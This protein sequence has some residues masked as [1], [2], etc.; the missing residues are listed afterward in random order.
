MKDIKS[1][2]I[3][4]L[5][6]GW[7][8]SQNLGDEAIFS[9]LIQSV[10]KLPVKIT[11]FSINETETRKMHRINTAPFEILPDTTRFIKAITECDIMLVGGGG[12]LQDQTS[13]FNVFRYLYKAW[14]GKLLG[15]K[16]MFY[17]VGAGPVNYKLTKFFVRVVL[18][19]VDAI[20]VRDSQ[21]QKLLEQIGVKKELITLSF[22]PVISLKPADKIISENIYKNETGDNPGK[23]VIGICLRHWYDTHPLLP[24]ALAQRLDF[25][26]KDGKDKYEKF[27]GHIA[28]AID[29]LNDG[30]FTFLFIPFWFSRDSKVH[31]DV[32]ERLKNKAN[33]R[34][35]TKP[36][37]P[38]ELLGLFSKLD[39]L[40]AMRLHACIFA[41][42]VATP[43]VA[44]SY[45]SKVDNFLEELGIPDT[46]IKLDDLN[47]PGL[48]KIFQEVQKNKMLLTRT[49]NSTIK[50]SQELEDK[51]FQTFKKIAENE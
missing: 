46:K 28:E 2:N 31:Q 24:V 23:T 25:K 51:N 3:K 5:V 50:K 14:L 6:A 20:T 15:K 22:D 10:Q 34:S 18:N 21:S 19:Q 40:W 16:V 45:T 32:I 1:K 29:N 44:L 36:Y 37:R 12:I 13:V 35:L 17:A 49:I 47:T 7:I 30:R 39:Y 38:D 9:S 43:F 27:V 4:V 48:L 26:Q 33:I 8:G 42:R 41:A 11:A